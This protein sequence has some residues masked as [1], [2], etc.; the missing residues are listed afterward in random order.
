M[1]AAASEQTMFARFT[2]GIW[3]SAG[4]DNNDEEKGSGRKVPRG[5]E[6]ILKRT[7]K[8]INHERDAEEKKAAADDSEDSKKEEDKKDA[9]ADSDDEK[10]DE[11]D[12]DKKKDNKEEEQESWKNRIYNYFMEP[13][14][15][16]PN[17]ENWLKLV[18]L[19]G[20]AG[21]YLMFM[22]QPSQEVTYMDFINNYLTKN[23]VEMITL[24]E[25]K[26]NAAYKYRAII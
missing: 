13:N 23:S 12:K 1:A 3:R 4:G 25:D 21:Y 16:G 19:G 17:Y 5:F 24:C 8:G 7:R 26:N 18:V 20:V 11:K 15:G 2:S 14:G 22:Q 9:D 6:K 10:E